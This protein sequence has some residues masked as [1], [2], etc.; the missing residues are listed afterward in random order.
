M[1]NDFK[2]LYK[3]ESELNPVAEDVN[4]DLVEELTVEFE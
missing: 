2:D 3:M 1:M 4:S